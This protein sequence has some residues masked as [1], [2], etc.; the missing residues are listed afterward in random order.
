MRLKKEKKSLRNFTEN[1]DSK[2][3]KERVDHIL[4]WYICKASFY[5]TLYYSL[6]VVLIMINASIPIINQIEF[7]ESSLLVSI[8]SSVATVIT[9][10]ITLFAM[11]DTWYRYRF[12]VE[13][14]KKE[15]M[16]FNIKHKMYANADRNE[17]FIERFESIIEN[18]RAMWKSDKFTDEDC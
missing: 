18:E 12:S 7:R 15:C 9:S 6:S 10:V 5:K 17:I 16:L 13:L 8:I 11:K 14:M 3:I 2:I 4:E 1:I